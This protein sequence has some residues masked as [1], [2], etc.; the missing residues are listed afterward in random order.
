M[1]AQES[2]IELAK[3]SMKFSAGHFTI[4][5]ANER[6]NLHGHNFTVYAGLKVC[7]DDNGMAFDYRTYK[8]KLH[9]LC[10]QLNQ[11]LLIPSRSKYLQ[12][13]ED[14]TYYHATFDNERMSFLKRDATILPL[15]NITVEELSAWF[16]EQLCTDEQEL[17]NNQITTIV[18]KVFTAPGQSGSAQREISR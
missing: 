1:K 15:T 5:S 2:W 18:I 4:F 14:D 8:K 9:Q 10:S 11:T 6:E 13:E 16:V 7:F 12:I 3:E 17:Y